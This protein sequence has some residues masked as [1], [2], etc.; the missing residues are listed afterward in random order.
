MVAKFA[1]FLSDRVVRLNFR[2]P[3]ARGDI[4]GLIHREGKVIS[5]DYEGNDV[6]LTAVVP[7]DL[8]GRVAEFQ[9]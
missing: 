9:V 1:E 5:T 4:S 6:L 7:K 3:Q 8:A 2:I